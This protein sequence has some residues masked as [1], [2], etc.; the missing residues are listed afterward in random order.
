MS[1]CD[2]APAPVVAARNEAEPAPSDAA[3]ALEALATE[4]GVIGETSSENPV[5]SYGRAYDGGEDRLCLID[6]GEARDDGMT[7]N[8]GVEIRIGEEEYCRG[9]GVARRSDDRLILNF[10]GGCAISARYEGDR[11]VMP[12]AV[13]AA[14]A[15]LCSTRGSLAGV[16]FPRQSASTRMSDSEGKP[17]CGG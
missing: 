15:R 4:R 5:G 6:I 8:V 3:V 12:G 7:Y 17:L 10:A 14:C 13:D 16:T 11:L 1:A 9:I 2:K